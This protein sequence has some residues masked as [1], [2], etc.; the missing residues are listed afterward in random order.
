MDGRGAVPSSGAPVDDR[1]AHFQLHRVFRARARGRAVLVSEDHLGPVIREGLTADELLAEARAG[2]ARLGPEQALAALRAG[3]T[4]VDIRSIDQRRAG[5]EVPGALRVA[6]NVL[7]WRVDPRSRLRAPGAPELDAQVMLLCQEG[8]A[9]SL[10]AA[11][12][13]R[14]G[15]AR[16]TDV[17]GGFEAWRA[18]LLPV[19]PF[20]A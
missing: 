11:T 5:G 12:L 10:A 9:S 13:Q 15:F 19:W 14:M 18:E 3:A 8:F 17:V 20:S 7:E 6:R 1:G 16:A 2:L 4:L